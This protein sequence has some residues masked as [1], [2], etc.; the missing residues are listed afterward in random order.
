[1]ALFSR[2][3]D[4][5]T[6]DAK[7]DDQSSEAVVDNNGKN[8]STDSAKQST[9]RID[10]SLHDVLLRPLITEKATYL[11]DDGVYTFVVKK[12][13]TKPEIKQAIKEVYGISARKVR[14][15]KMTKKA[16]TSRQGKDSQKGGGKKAYV[17]LNEGDSIDLI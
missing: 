10:N 16:V 6:E 3:K 5:S 1:M 15:A 9:K 13:A 8:E 17:Y 14:T 7:Q 11:T 2:T 4:E 12:S